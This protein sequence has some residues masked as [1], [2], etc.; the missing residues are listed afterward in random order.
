MHEFKI[1]RS[2]WVRGNIGGPS[3][4]LNERDNKC[5]LGFLCSSYGV[6]DDS[7]LGKQTPSKI[8]E[9]DNLPDW[10]IKLQYVSTALGNAVLTVYDSYASN[11]LMGINDNTFLTEEQREQKIADL[12]AAHDVKVTFVD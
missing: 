12:L 10:L 2:E 7:L 9:H 6:S 5:C 1:Q 8:E 4:L 11:I 3:C